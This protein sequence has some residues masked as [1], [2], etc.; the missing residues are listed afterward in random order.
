MSKIQPPL[1]CVMEPVFLSKIDL[2]NR[3]PKQ[4]EL[5]F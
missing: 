4:S 2:A 3:C 1:S 5:V